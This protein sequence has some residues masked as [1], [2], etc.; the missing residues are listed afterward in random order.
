MSRRP[1]PH[2]ADEDGVDNQ[3]EGGIENIDQPKR[4][5]VLEY[6]SMSLGCG[7]KSTERIVMR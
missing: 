1:Q 2:S 6:E 3:M 4:E 7:P 5:K